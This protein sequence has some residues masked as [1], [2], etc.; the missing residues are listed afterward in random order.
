[1][2]GCRHFPGVIAMN[3]ALA[4][5]APSNL[6]FPLWASPKIDGVRA[7]VL[8]G[9]V[10][11]R[12]GKPIPSE[13]VQ[14][15]Y[16]HL[17]GHDGELVH[18]TFAETTSSVMSRSGCGARFVVFDRFDRHGPHDV[19][20]AAVDP[21]A[22]KLAHTLVTDQA[23]LDALEASCLEAGYEGLILRDPRAEYVQGRTRAMMKLK[24]FED[25]EAF[26]TGFD[27]SDRVGL[28]GAF[29]VRKAGTGEEFRVGAGLRE[30]QRVDF[31][32]MR[33][34]LVGKLLRYRYFPTLG[35]TAPRHA[36]FSGFRDPRDT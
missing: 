35:M 17:E 14:R 22:D 32:R 34:R 24:R 11:S 20:L 8:G 7:Y 1:M 2:R 30:D 29:V 31:W 21:G 3:P 13:W 27:E 18:G 10:L 9:V 28:L 12:S 4:T 26:V 33:E 16:G 25:D 23:Q 15:T 36:V 6:P 5:K 19:R